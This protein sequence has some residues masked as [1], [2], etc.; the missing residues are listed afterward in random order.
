MTDS[1][2]APITV[3]GLTM[4][5]TPSEGSSWAIDPTTGRV[6][7]VAAPHSDIFVDPGSGSQINAETLFNA[8]TL[9]GP[10]PTGDFQLRARVTVDF[11][12]KYDAG[13]L[14][15]CFDQTL[16]A[17]LC[18]EFSPAGERMVVSVVNRGVSDD[19]NGFVVPDPSV[20]L[21]VSRLGRVWAF[22]ASTDGA[23]WRL[24][25]AFGL[26][27]DPSG[28]RIGL[29]AQSPTGEGCAVSFEELRLSTETLG[30]LRDGS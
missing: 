11:A 5:L 18:F 30:D 8:V 28:L 12:A 24:I 7:G 19:A 6:D 2:R 22:H 4:P 14:L 26:D 16:W 9:L 20:W 10:A 15:L 3:P 27:G 1:T 23:H 25:R 13:A 29:E 21:R 17:K